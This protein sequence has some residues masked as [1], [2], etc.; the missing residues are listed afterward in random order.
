MQMAEK[1]AGGFVPPRVVSQGEWLAARKRLLEKEKALTH[2]RDAVSAERRRLPMVRIEKDYLFEST[3]GRRT[4]AQL[5]DDRSQLIVYHFM[6]APG[7][8]QCCPSCS[9]LAD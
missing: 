9:F 3:H 8:E 7:W 4:L 2:Q 5:F 1:S 6:F